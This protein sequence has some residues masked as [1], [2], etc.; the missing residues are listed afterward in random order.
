MQTPL[1]HHAL[2]RSNSNAN[3]PPSLSAFVAFTPIERT[4]QSLGNVE[5]T[6]AKGQPANR[7]GCG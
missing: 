3:T 4:Y 6:E 1:L 5:A 7:P 2:D